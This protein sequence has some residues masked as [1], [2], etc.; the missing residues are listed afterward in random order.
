MI[1]E[2]AR[3]FRYLSH[4]QVIKQWFRHREDHWEMSHANIDPYKDAA[5]C[6]AISFIAR[7]DLRIAREAAA[8]IDSFWLGIN[9]EE[10]AFLLFDI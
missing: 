1:L 5:Y 2:V 6:E 7:R 9:S 3:T 4:T 8:S 10:D